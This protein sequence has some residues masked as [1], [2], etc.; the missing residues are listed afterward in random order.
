[1]FQKEI[2]YLDYLKDYQLQKNHSATSNCDV[3]FF[4][5]SYFEPDRLVSAR[6]RGISCLIQVKATSGF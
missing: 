6:L 4:I 1:M 3:A 2:K 5:Q